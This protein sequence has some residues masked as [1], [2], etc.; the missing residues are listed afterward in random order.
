MVAVRLPPLS[1]PGSVVA[2]LGPGVRV[3][4]PPWSSGVGVTFALWGVMF[5]GGGN[6]SGA[7]DWPG[8]P[9]SKADQTALLGAQLLPALMALHNRGLAHLDVKPDNIVLRD[10]RPVLI[11][12]GRARRIGSE[13]PP[14]HPVGTVGY[15]SPEQEAC[16]PVSVAMDLYSLGQT[17]AEAGAELPASLQGLIAQQPGRRLTTAEALTALAETAG[18]L[19]PW[20]AWLRA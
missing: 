16:E 3:R 1:S 12:F 13:Q 4:S 15:A 19:R 9:G 2:V 7:G 11:D 14:G 10:A 6:H 8:V 17:L 20:P 5:S 18:A